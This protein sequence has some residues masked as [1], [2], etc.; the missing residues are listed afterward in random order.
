MLSHSGR[1][2]RSIRRGWLW[3]SSAGNLLPAGRHHADR[4]RSPAWTEAAAIVAAAIESR[5]SEPI[6]RRAVPTVEPPLGPRRADLVLSSPVGQRRRLVVAG[7]KSI[8]GSFGMHPDL[9]R[10]LVAADC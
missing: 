4:R 2:L 1:L 8:G 5:M 10:R 3:S 9:R 7:K 6:S